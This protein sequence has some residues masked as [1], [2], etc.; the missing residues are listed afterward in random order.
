MH[1]VNGPYQGGFT[2]TR[3]ANNT[4]KLTLSDLKAYIIQP[5]YT[6]GISLA[7]MI[8]YN[9]SSSGKR[10]EGYPSAHHY[11]PA[12]QFCLESSIAFLAPS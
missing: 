11:S 1:P 4:Y 12:T 7:H 10:A 8:K 3:Q 5:L 9:H 2:R 6:I